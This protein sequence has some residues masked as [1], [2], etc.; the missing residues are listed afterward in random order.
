MQEGMFFHALYNKHSTAYF[1]QI[2][3][4]LHGSLKIPFVEKSLNELFKRYDILR[5][6]FVQKTGDRLLQVVLKERSVD[7][8]FEDIRGKP[9]KESYAAR[10]K[11]TDRKHLFDLT[12]DV[13]MRV[14][15]LRMGP[16]EYEFAWSH[17]HILMDGWCVGIIISEFWEIYNSY[18]ENRPYQLAPV[19]PFRDYL[20]W[21]EQQDKEESRNYW[22][23]Y[24][25]GYMAST[26]LPRKK[27]RSIGEKDNQIA[28]VV[29]TLDE[30]KTMY[31]NQLAGSNHVSM[32]TLVQ[33]LWGIL[34][35]R[36]NDR[37][38]VVF[39]SVVS[40][41]PPG[42]EDVESMVGLF[43]NTIPVRIHCN[44]KTPFK[45]LIR[46]VQEDA[47]ES[48]PYHYCQLADILAVSSLK[49]ELLD[50]I[51]ALQNFPI[52]QHI[53]TF[54]EGNP[55]TSGGP[56]VKISN[57][58][59]FEQTHYDFYLMATPS[60]QLSI[61]LNYNAD[62][63]EKE[64]VE[65]AACHFR[66]LFYC[67][68]D[69]E[70]IMVDQLSLLSEEERKQIIYDFNNTESHYPEDKR[71]HE[72]FEEQAER[73]GDKIAVIGMEHGA[74]SMGRRAGIGTMSITYRELNKKSTQ[75]ANVLM[76]KGVASGDIVG[77]MIERSVE[78]VIGI[79][80]ILKAGGA[81]LPID[82]N[83]PEDRKKYMLV[84]SSTKI[85]LTTR[86]LCTSTVFA[87]DI[88]YLEDNKKLAAS[89]ADQPAV[90]NSQH[91]ASSKNIAYVIYTSGST[92][93]P[94]GV[95][96]EH[97]S[98][99]NFVYSFYNRFNGNF[100][101]IDI[102]AS[103]TNITFDVS[104]C[105]IFV[106]L[107]FGSSLF[108]LPL[109]ELYDAEQLSRTLVE[110]SITFA[111]IH[112]HL[113]K[114]V[115]ENLEACGTQVA[116]NK[117]LVGVEPIKDHVLE[118]FLHINQSM[119][120]INGYGPTE[121]TIC[122]SF[123]R[124]CSREPEGMNVPIGTPLPNN[125]IILL[126]RAYHLVPI[127]VPGELCIAGAGVARG[128]LNNPELTVEKFDQDLQDL[129]DE[130]DKKGTAVRNSSITV[131]KI[132]NSTH[133]L[134]YSP[135]Y[136]T[137][138]LARW[139]PDGNIEF[140]GRIDFQV[141]IRGYRI[142][143]GEI[144]NQLLKYESIKETVVTAVENESG[145]LS[146]CAYII[147]HEY[148]S[149]QG[150]DLPG[151][152][153]FLNRRLP[154]YMIPSHF[155][156]LEKIPLTPNG[157]I[158]RKGLPAPGEAS[159]GT[160]GEYV[161]PYTV[162]EKKLVEVWQAVLGRSNIGINENFFM[163]GGD[164]IKSIQ[165]ASQMNQAGYLVEI[166][167][168]FRHPTIS[169][170]A[171][172]VKK[173]DRLPDQSTITGK[174]PLTP[175]Q[176]RFFREYA[177][178]RHH[179]NQSVM[180]YSEEEF[181]Q[182]AINVIFTKIREHHDALRM[183]YKE[184]KGEVVQ[185]NHGLE[186]PLSLQVIDF[187]NRPDAAEALTVKANEIQAS[188][189]LEKGPLMRI[190]IFR[191]ND[192]DRLLIVIHHLVIDGVSWRIL[193]Q[194]IERLYQQYQKGEP[195]Q[196]PSK[197]DS[198]KYWS[199]KLSQ[200]A[201]SNDESFL[202][203][204]AWWSQLES[205]N[206]PLIKKDFEEGTN[207]RKDAAH[208][209][210]LLSEEET[211]HL[212]TKVHHPF[213]TEIN[214]ILL[215]ALVLGTRKT[216]GLN[217]LVIA[218]EGHGR[219]DILKDVN[220]NR[221]VGWFTT[222]YPIILTL[223]G[224]IY[225]DDLGRQVKEIKETLRRVPH[226]GTGYGILK[227][228]TAAPNKEGIDFNLNPQVS[229]NYLGQFGTEL[230]EISFAV[231]KESPGHDQSLRGEREYELEVSGL[232]THSQLEMSIVYSKNQYRRQTV[233]TLLENYKTQLGKLID[234]CSTR[235]ERQP[236]PADFTYK[237]LSIDTVDAIAVG[238]RGYIK[239]IYTLAPM[240]EGMLFHALYDPTSAAY[241]V[242]TSFRLRGQLDVPAAEKSLNQLF[243]RYDILRTF[244]IHS[245]IERPIQVVLK[246]RD[247]D[248]FYEDISDKATIEEKELFIK[249]FK[250][251]DKERSFDLNHDVL[252]RLSVIQTDAHVYEF[253]WSFHHILMD[254]W[255]L[256]IL[257]SEFFGIY[258]RYLQKKPLDLPP[259]IPYVRY[260]QW[261]EAKDREK[262]KIYWAAYLDSYEEAAS[263]PPIEEPGFGVSGYRKEA[264]SLVLEKEKTASLKRIAASRYVTLNTLI[265]ASWGILLSR[266][267]GTRDVVFGSVV[268]GRTAEI[269]GIES[270]V[271]LFIN[272]VP[273]RVRYHRSTTFNRLIQRLQEEALDSEP[274]HHYPLA[275]IQS[276]T[277]LKQKLLDHI[278]VFENYPINR[279]IEETTDKN[280][281]ELALEIL[282][283]DTVE[284]TNYDLNV[285]I[286]PDPELKVT[287]EYNGHAYTRQLIKQVGR[288]F[289]HLLDQILTISN[290]TNLTEPEPAIDTI[291]LLQEEEK[292]QLLLDFNN[293]A[294]EYPQDKIV[295]QLF[296]EQAGRAGDKIA[297]ISMEPR[298]LSK[299]G[300]TGIGTMS[301]TYRELN[302]KS[303][304]LA[305]LLREKGVRP[306]DI[307]I[308]GIMADRSVEMIIGVL[309]ILK[310]G[311]AYLPID[312]N[313][314]PAR[315]NY[316]IKD[317]EI[318]LLLTKKGFE[319]ITNDKCEVIELENSHLYSG[320][321]KNLETLNTPNDLAYIIYTSG[322]T[323]KPKGV[324][325]EHS[326]LIN[327]LYVLFEMYPFSGSDTYLLKTSFLF[328]VSITELFGWFPQ[329]GRLAILEKDGEKDPSVI[330]DAIERYKVTHINFVP[331]M[332]NAFVDHLSSED[333]FK[334]S[335][336]KYIFLAGEAIPPE[337]VKKF[338]DLNSNIPLE[339]LYGPTEATVYASGYS[340]SH[341][342][343]GTHIP[344][345]KPLLNTKLYILG[346]DNN[347]IPTG[348]LGELYISGAGVTRGYLNNS[349]LTEQ[350]FISNPFVEVN[351]DF[352]RYRRMYKTGDLVRWLPD[353]NIEFRGRFD[354]Q[355]KIRGF[356][357]ETGEIER[358][359][360]THTAIKDALVTPSKTAGENTGAET[361]EKYLCA[362]IVPGDRD[363]TDTFKVSEL[364]DYLLEQLPGFMIP[365]Y[366]VKLQNFPL[367]PNGKIDRNAL[368]DPVK[369]SETDEEFVAPQTTIEKQLM[370]IWQQVLGKDVIGIHDNFFTIG[371]DSIKAIQILSRLSK[372]G[373]RIEMREFFMNPSIAQLAV[374]VQKIRQLAD[375]SV[376]TG[377]VPLTPIQ[378]EF[379]EKHPDHRHHYNQAM[380]LYWA[381]GFDPE[382]IREV[383]TRIQEHHD[384][385]RMTC[386]E[387]KGEIIQT[388]HGLDYPLSLQV[389]DLRNQKKA[390]EAVEGHANEI[391]ASINLETGPL[392]KIGLF[393]LDDGDRLLIVIHHL[394]IDGISWRILF[395]DIEN[396]Y[397]HFNRYKEKEKPP[398]LPPKTGSFKLWSEILSQHGASSSDDF[399]KEKEYW[400]RL[401]AS[402]PLPPIKKDFEGGSNEVKDSK[403]RSYYLSREDTRRLL[404]E[405]NHA[406]GT[407]IND[408]LLTAL[409]L[410]V[411][412]KYGLDRLLVALEGHGREE[413]LRDMD[414][415]RTVGWFTAIYPV[416]L[417]FS[418][419][420]H[421]PGKDDLSRQVKEIKER[422]RQ[423]PR[424]GIGYGILKYLAAAEH[425]KDIEFKLKPRVSFNYLGQFNAEAEEISFEAAR[426]SPGNN[427]SPMMQNDFEWII[428][429]IVMQEQM[430]LSVTYSKKQ[431]K[432]ETIEAVLQLFKS[433]LCDIIA[434]CS[435]RGKKER[436]PGDLTYKDLSI[437]SFE[438]IDALF[439]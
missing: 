143:L 356:R 397:Q 141:K 116:L 80:A 288:Q 189:N 208:C 146:L 142:E 122:A 125:E 34:L 352:N 353:G 340:L 184:E 180:L 237:Q 73:A 371:G 330:V 315:I 134:T 169:G 140:L 144:E 359:L 249:E 316:I 150:I 309:S 62:V 88:I 115:S 152:H 269:E 239:D 361:G 119:Q 439:D 216:Y 199:E 188:F 183:T 311:G 127:G 215:T 30:E 388:N 405:V 190:A 19:R 255:C 58:Q 342:A 435:E 246:E 335:S 285:I 268:A 187:R 179:F 13:L 95:V 416:L 7:F 346:K 51:I 224:G 379:F 275:N 38:E 436:T 248:F 20:E 226:K 202:K 72:L 123:Y 6:V 54:P 326:S 321:T 407:E 176:E 400:A 273:V 241:F 53:E 155:V 147:P 185:T 410:A 282:N 29:V 252:M 314:P 283:V 391:Q 221:T 79:L 290:R 8:H 289:Y 426:E 418:H 396:L 158:D 413:I 331:S 329:G 324:I 308:V 228:L 101:P 430:V 219:E 317:S 135:I 390:E 377:V 87:K 209:S 433:K 136:R 52:A 281:K 31:L 121:A 349:E 90:H 16:E 12:R 295:H 368:P 398:V 164:S 186:Y 428:T 108:I 262:S 27:M 102:C 104:V 425:K 414:I 411:R 240:Q 267:N 194:D 167:D 9:E 130:Q 266:Y 429:C 392:M 206:V 363:T 174:V 148:D 229:F 366:F 24:L 120:I 406:F 118:S 67:I 173:P 55:N 394:V 165:V 10:Y 197:T 112:P 291:T 243:K 45:Q 5:T 238:T 74:W 149:P 66:N 85:L 191:M 258:T 310:A 357:I 251:K 328:D 1:E 64:M 91:A 61:K 220:I 56:S 402:P 124:Y 213:G 2:S 225:E 313:Y 354:H 401:E 271:G 203:E 419:D 43:I 70:E 254:G 375:Q 182:E 304:Q 86:N 28:Q 333:L 387:E 204:R 409:G 338:R 138:D 82:P 417:D 279:Q 65:Q 145:D 437:D 320:E 286:V 81:Y 83:Y 235:Y 133:P 69:N 393:Q 360:R 162:I 253:T 384:A 327:I 369:G 362:Y 232:I 372:L 325:I 339:N 198:F 37:E 105:E 264:V 301:I 245:N 18:M 39:G 259:V 4:R 161:P 98:I 57:V 427:V 172:T 77:I 100:M 404:T 23:K 287:M 378:V 210:F 306:D 223:P 178:D 385:L 263:I 265:Q 71:I 358:C 424:K 319:N 421:S 302:E 244:F 166:K 431:Y 233:D 15:V 129:Q 434:Y 294:V 48:E 22:K 207:Y 408:I 59:N 382:I 96:V 126:D 151:L 163:I 348:V 25:E 49:Q 93:K 218:L 32:N 160:T 153:D 212:L 214:D 107:V 277:S 21:L 159:I 63:Y 341:W 351:T 50:H 305:H 250:Q 323:G 230:G 110:K 422:L 117:M 193:F 222:L 389:Y 236:T 415:S 293:T 154:A 380:M 131:S 234:Y 300:W 257:I 205:Q 292:K 276:E 370:G 260:I 171:S 99:T 256:G 403:I 195:L 227:Y 364:R 181:S 170:L 296:E 177:I 89:L 139:L 347:L 274:H 420:S 345:G 438:S 334:C 114:D 278:L 381:E 318:R 42:I 103:I 156:L 303:N 217:Q 92:G 336:L 157:K 192:G 3:F 211:E 44:G 343:G 47:A 111:Y 76:E 106:P 75:L 46:K 322:S 297:V 412:E 128:Y 395:E 201:N 423:V 280:K 68:I 383:F 299:E 168:I 175:I 432:P 337:L 270:M 231:A 40:G 399:S 109:D 36:Y 312:P 307:G 247:G 84:Y 242:Q 41:R 94:N 355:V 272:T 261:L 367:S 26:G 386:R 60:E 78:M 374:K 332:F 97:S 365:S 14:A 344:I 376:V 200:Y 350:A 132:Y 196:L 17:H 11:E 298:A 284:Q 373:Y 137:G 113:L 35:S 33:T